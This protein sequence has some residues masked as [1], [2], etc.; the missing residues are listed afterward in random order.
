MVS[1]YPS[2]RETADNI[3]KNNEKK[4]LTII[5][6]TWY[7]ITRTN[8]CETHRKKE[9][10]KLLTQRTDGGKIEKSLSQ[11]RQHKT[12]KTIAL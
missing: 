4:L 2:P 6:K 8:K 1:L 9:L 10:K 5:A 11:R 3:E 7:L 12:S